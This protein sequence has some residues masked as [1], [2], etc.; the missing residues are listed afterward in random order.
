MRTT[1]IIFVLFF[2]F[3]L[4]AKESDAQVN[5]ELGY[6]YA[7]AADGTLVKSKPYLKSE[8]H[9]K[10][11]EEYSSPALDFSFRAQ[12]RLNESNQKED[13]ELRSF[14][15]TQKGK[16]YALDWGLQNIS[17]SETFGFNILDLVNPRD[18]SEYVFED[19]SWVQLPVWALKTSLIYENLK[20]QLIYVPR[21]RNAVLPRAGSYYDLLPASLAGIEREAYKKKEVFR[22][23]EWGVRLEYLFDFGLDLSLIAYEHFNRTPSYYLE[24]GRLLLTDRKLQSFATSFTY[25]YEGMVL[26]GDTLFT[27][28]QPS[29]SK[30][31]Q[32]KESDDWQGI[33][34]VDYTFESQWTM[35]AQYQFAKEAKNHWGALQV[36]KT[37]G[38]FDLQGLYFFG[39]N[40]SDRWLRPE[41]TWHLPFSTSLRVYYDYIYGQGDEGVLSPFK[42][43][44]VFGTNWNWLF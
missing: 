17:W 31:L 44:D 2:V 34:G 19:L 8:I 6:R 42:R 23:A 21:A 14:R 30:D 7:Y 10:F 43:R 15:L 5:S 27:L 40:N 24:N 26:R 22:D 25:A 29:F 36:K 32:Y 1:F 39:L 9:K 4:Q 35:G 11:G 13:V 28:S 3:S 12:E 41:F 33:Y 37:F 38:D 18:W 16:Y 20:L